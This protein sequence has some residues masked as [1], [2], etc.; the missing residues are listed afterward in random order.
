MQNGTYKALFSDKI[1]FER[2]FGRRGRGQGRGKGAKAVGAG[3][4]IFGLSPKISNIAL[5]L[6]GMLRPPGLGNLQGFVGYATSLLGLPL[7]LMLGVHNDGE[8]PEVTT[9]FWELSCEG[10]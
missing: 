1:R 10:R 9:L 4:R 3:I 5:N 6:V 2:M 8:S 7:D